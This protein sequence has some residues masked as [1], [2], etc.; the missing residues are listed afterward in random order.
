MADCIFC[1]IGSKKIR[2]LVVY[3][4]DE[5]LAFRDI[6]PA[7]P[8]H[9][10]IIPKQHFSGLSDMGPEQVPLLGKMVAAARHIATQEKIATTGYRLVINSG[11]NG[12]QSV[13]HVHLHLLGG[14]PL[15]W[16]P[17]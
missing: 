15:H 1:G 5:L 17:G 4:D 2:S 7:A 11:E 6:N 14:R 9:I 8:V 12:G 3:E 10:L 13:P 16:P